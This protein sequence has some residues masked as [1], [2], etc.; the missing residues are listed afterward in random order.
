MSTITGAIAFMERYFW[1]AYLVI[2]LGFTVSRFK[3][4][5]HFTRHDGLPVGKIMLR[6]GSTL[7]KNDFI[8]SCVGFSARFCRPMYLTMQGGG[9]LVLYDGMSSAIDSTQCSSMSNMNMK[10]SKKDKWNSENPD[11]NQV[12]SSNKLQNCSNKNKQTF[13]PKVVFESGRQ[14]MVDVTQKNM[15]FQEYKATVTDNGDLIIYR[16]KKVVWT[17]TSNDLLRHSVLSEILVL[18]K[19][20]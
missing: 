3:V 18:Q 11:Q 2:A 15:L 17:L 7:Y 10:P 14:N 12:S 5:P 20:H 13:K 8:S 4:L 1:M 16:G 6:R 19:L 9:N